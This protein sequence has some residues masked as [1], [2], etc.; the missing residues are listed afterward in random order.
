MTIKMHKPVMITL[1]NCI[2]DDE[3]PNEQSDEQFE[4]LG[5][6]LNEYGYLGDLIVVNPADKKGKNFVHHG[7]HRIKKLI[8]EGVTKAWGFIVKMNKLQHKAYRQAMNK[9]HGSH[10]PAKDKL[11]LEYF[12]KQNK[13]E[14]LSSLIAQPT[15]Q[16][17]ILQE[18]VLI[19]R[20]EDVDARI[21]HEDTF[22]HGNIKQIYLMFSNAEYEKV[23]LKIEKAMKISKTEN[24]TEM[25]ITTLNFYLKGKK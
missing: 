7:E 15:E 1:A 21:H 5:T 20:K 2:F 12:A 11:E 14:F 6:S 16:L 22:L 18:P 9:L 25:F 17:M 19:E 24:H 4:S 8:E 13:L 3:N 10:D 23:M